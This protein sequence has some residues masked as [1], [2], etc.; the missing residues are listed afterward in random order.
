M[1]G[2]QHVVI[3]EINTSLHLFPITSYFLCVN[4]LGN[5]KMDLPNRDKQQTIAVKKT[6][7]RDLQNDNKM[8][9]PTSVGSSSFLKDKDLPTDSNRVLGIKRSLSDYPVNHHLQQPLG[10]NAANGPLVYVRRKSEAELVKSTACENSNIN[11]YCTHSRQLCCDEEA[12]HTKPCTKEPKVSCFPAFAPFPVASSMNSSGKP[13]V[14]I[15]LGKSAMRLAP[16]ESNYVTA[17]SSPTIGNPKGLK[18]V[19]WEERYHQLQMFLRKLTLSDQEE[20]IQML[21]SLSSVELSR[22]AVELEKR[23][24]QLSLEEAKELQRVAVLN[25]LGKPVKNIKAPAVHDEY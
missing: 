3:L 25:V 6:A 2:L 7:L 1:S 10:N 23:S 20:Y 21:R 15:S 12:A 22:H 17:S 14:P 11:A 24:I 13:S 16:A 9:A 19:H 4:Y 8:T 18:N 5:S